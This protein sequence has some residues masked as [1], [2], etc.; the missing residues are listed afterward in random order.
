L[1]GLR[2]H[3]KAFTKIDAGVSVGPF[4][5]LGRII[6]D[7]VSSC[8]ANR[9]LCAASR[10]VARWVFRPLRYFDYLIKDSPA[11]RRSACEYYMLFQKT[12]SQIINDAL[13]ATYQK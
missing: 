2:V 8:V 4:C 10:F 6:R 9:F 12:D 3:T 13:Y 1:E 7:G 5:A 11:A